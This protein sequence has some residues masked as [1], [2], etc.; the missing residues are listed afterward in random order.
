M[1]GY[2]QLHEKVTLQILGFDIR[3]LRL[4]L[5]SKLFATLNKILEPAKGSV[6]IIDQSFMTED[7]I[8]LSMGM[9]SVLTSSVFEN[10]SDYISIELSDVRIDLGSA[11]DN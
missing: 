8:C 4:P 9:Q 1:T 5:A 6:I 3:L 2:D 7:I 11:D 10:Q